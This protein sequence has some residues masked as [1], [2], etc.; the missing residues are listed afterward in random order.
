MKPWQRQVLVT[1]ATAILIGVGS[2]GVHVVS[3]VY[4]TEAQASQNQ[5]DIAEGAAV[6]KENAKRLTEM[7]KTQIAILCAVAP[8][9]CPVTP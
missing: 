8:D 3:T 1:I 5:K 4:A 2:G 7:E 9:K 6:A